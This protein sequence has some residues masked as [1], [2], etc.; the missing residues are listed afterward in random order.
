MTD[1]EKILVRGFVADA[2][3][4][5]ANFC[6]SMAAAMTTGVHDMLTGP[7]ALMLV[8][9]AFRDCARRSDEP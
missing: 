7:E 6:E 9:A 1:R 8:A 5:N 2:T 3:R 4:L